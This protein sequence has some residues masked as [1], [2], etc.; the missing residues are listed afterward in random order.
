MPPV[1]SAYGWAVVAGAFT[2]NGVGFGILYSFTVFFNPILEEFGIGRGVVSVVAS[3]A[4]ALMLGSGAFIGRLA[5]RFGPQ[6]MIGAGSIL[7]LLGLLLAS[8]STAIWQVLLS[9]GVLL[10]LGVGSCF[11]PSNA[12]VGQW[13]SNRRG[14]ATGIAVS[15]SGVGSVIMAP[16][17]EALISTYD[18]RVALRIIAVVGVVLLLAAAAVVKGRGT[19]RESTVLSSIRSNPIFRIFFSSAAVASYGYWVPFVHIVPYARD[20]GITAASAALLV[21][22]MGV[23]NIIGRVVLGSVADRFGRR[24]II[25][26]ALASMACSTF[27]WPLADSM[28]TLL[29]FTAVYGF[30]A[31]TFISLLFALTADYFGIERLAG[32]TGLVN[33][34]AAIGTLLGAPLSGVLFDA[35]GT[36][37][38]AIIIAG[39]TI[40]IG[41]AVM[42]ALPPVRSGAE[43]PV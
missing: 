33:S 12:A 38:V 22:V 41:T 16:M 34:A 42:L 6:K 13:F 32:V 2:A 18:W 21:S 28:P 4:A 36:Y 5:D 3:I 1:E 20:H 37:T 9:Y 43:A 39:T 8:I 11:L 7:L 40:A 14:L 25:Q 26:V 19:R 31:G 17:S 35:T 27:L 15:G 24:R 10:G 23:A 29:V 30:F